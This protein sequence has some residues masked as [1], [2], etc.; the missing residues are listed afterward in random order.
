MQQIG[1]RFARFVE[2]LEDLVGQPSI[3]SGAG[4]GPF[5]RGLLMQ[6]IDQHP[7]PIGVA[8]VGQFE[9]A[10]ADLVVA[11]S[12]TPQPP[13]NAQAILIRI[14]RLPVL[15]GQRLRAPRVCLGEPGQ[16]RFLR[17]Q[18][19]GLKRSEIPDEAMTWHQ[20]DVSRGRGAYDRRRLAARVRASSPD[21]FPVPI[22]VSP[23]S[24]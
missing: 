10:S 11:T 6:T 2:A 13:S 7:T 1:G 12:E 16:A 4:Q 22:A 17:E 14:E 20:L 19:R 3:R 15:G 8:A 21:P 23:S 9:T 18:M 5:T 24:P